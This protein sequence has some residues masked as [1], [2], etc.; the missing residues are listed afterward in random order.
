M[1]GP[2]ESY[3]D[4]ILR[5]VESRRGVERPLTGPGDS[6]G[7]R[8]RM[9][10]DEH[11][12]AMSKTLF[13]YTPVVHA[14]KILCDGVIKRSTGETPPYV[15]LSSNPTNE[16]TASRPVLTSEQFRQCLADDRTVFALQR[17][18]RFVF[19]G[20]AATPWADL[21]GLRLAERRRLVRLAKRK[22]G[23]PQDWFTLPDDVP[24]LGLPLETQTL[25][26][27]WQEEDQGELKRRYEGLKV[28]F[29]GNRIPLFH[30]PP[31]SR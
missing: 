15:W 24:C 13:H 21:R 12:V 20:C 30:L 9:A 27:G 7:G 11:I 17:Q 2:G 16:P 4:V 28:E 5:L 18:A 6:P 31:R 19:H 14:L 1:R 3:S 29:D 8:P 10:C 23:R 26:G 22:G 25:E